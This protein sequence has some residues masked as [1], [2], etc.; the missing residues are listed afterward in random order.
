[1][2]IALCDI[3]TSPVNNVC[4]MLTFKGITERTHQVDCNFFGKPFLF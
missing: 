3:D 1:M 2:H 4:M